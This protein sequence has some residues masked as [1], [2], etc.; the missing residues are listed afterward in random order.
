MNGV[1]LR[2]D[3]GHFSMTTPNEIPPDESVELAFQ[4]AV[5]ASARDIDY[6]EFSF[7]VEGG[8]DDGVQYKVLVIRI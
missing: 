7:E 6:E 3:W 4:L 1:T 2:R 5:N 8:M